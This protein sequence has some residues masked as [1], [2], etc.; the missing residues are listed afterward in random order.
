MI[1]FGGKIEMKKMYKG[2]KLNRNKRIFRETIK[3]AEEKIAEVCNCPTCREGRSFYKARPK[4]EESWTVFSATHLSN[5]P[6]H[7]YEFGGMLRLKD[8]TA[9]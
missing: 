9:K 2:D 3:K 1:T 4:G 7:K 6:I 8:K 5:L